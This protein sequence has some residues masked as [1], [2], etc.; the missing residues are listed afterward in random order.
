MRLFYDCETSGLWK[1]ELDW[2]DPSQP[3]LLQLGLHFYDAKWNR[4]GHFVSMIRPDGWSIEPGAEEH[5]GISEARASRHGVP[6]VA[7]LTVLQAFS[8]NARRIIAHHNE[9]DRRVIR[10]EL[11]RCGSDGLW[12]Q[13]KA[14]LFF[15][16]M[17]AST[18]VCQLPGQFGFK[19]PSLEEAH[20]HFYPAQ[21]YTT[22][23]EADS[24]TGACADVFRGLQALGL[25]E[26]GQ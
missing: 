25:T 19:F 24:D 13:K 10:A 3:R 1:E 22:K 23:H 7:A 18:P 2:D 16:T 8:A 5:H 12:W 6:L 26:E 17:E 15:C 20:R 4:T 14:P 9:F 21:E 11:R